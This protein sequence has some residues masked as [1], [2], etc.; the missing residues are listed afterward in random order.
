MDSEQDRGRDTKK[1]LVEKEN[2]IQLLKKKLR[3]PATQLIQASE[4]TEL[5]NEKEILS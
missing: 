3:I 5:E 4:L 1:I 2:I